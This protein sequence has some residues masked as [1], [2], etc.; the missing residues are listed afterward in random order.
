MAI[1]QKQNTASCIKLLAAQRR[2]YSDAKSIFGTRVSVVF[3]AGVLSVSASWA[4][5]QQRV[6]IGGL[7]AAFG[8]TV[9]VFGSSREK[10]KIKEASSVQEL[11]DVSV[12]ELPWND[13]LIERPPSSV[14]NEAAKRYKAGRLSNWY[15]DTGA[16]PRPLDVVMCQ[17]TNLGWS[18]SAHRAWA[19]VVVG[20][21][22]I[23]FAYST[24]LSI[25]V[26][27][28]FAGAL[29]GFYVPLLP[30]LKEVVEIWRLNMESVA[31]K[32]KAEGKAQALWRRAIDQKRS[33]EESECRQLQD[34][35]LM[36]RQANALI[37]DWF[38][39]LRRASGE[40]VMSM[41]MGD[42]VEEATGAGLIPDPPP[43]S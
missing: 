39:W 16:A 8:F 27:S 30:T 28:S 43:V 38:Y 4:F 31:T 10:R 42:F 13:V 40:Q 26:A 34:L 25:F 19:A 12:F 24:L 22:F 6:L 11:F 35:I 37:P 18:A 33:P 29:V 7:A 2:L 9:S 17:R 21:G 41:S 3:V 32:Q 23:V 5:P 15:A 36:S 14:V 1:S 20:F